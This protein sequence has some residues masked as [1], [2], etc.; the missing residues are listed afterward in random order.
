MAF[1]LAPKTEIKVKVVIYE[2]LE[3]GNIDKSEC[4]ATFTRL[5]TSE[6]SAMAEKLFDKENDYSWK[7]AL[8]EYTKNVTPLLD[9]DGQ[10]L[11]FTPSV[12]DMLLDYQPT[13]AALL[14]SFTLLNTGDKE[15]ERRKNSKK[16]G[17]TGQLVRAN[18]STQKRNCACL[19]RAAHRKTF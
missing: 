3:D 14:D 4:Y 16:R 11:E 18:L 2:T 19:K 1:K 9:E 7:D 10:E 15:V 8:R 13:Y 5:K 6:W 17:S 12:L